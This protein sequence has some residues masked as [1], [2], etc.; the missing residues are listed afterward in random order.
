MPKHPGHLN[1]GCCNIFVF[2]GQSPG[3]Q[4][5]DHGPTPPKGGTYYHWW[6]NLKPNNYYTLGEESSC[7]LIRQRLI[8]VLAVP[9]GRKEVIITIRGTNEPSRQFAFNCP[10]LFALRR[11]V[12]A[13]TKWK[14]LCSKYSCKL[15]KQL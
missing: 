10:I 1:D 11:Q 13:S 9:P 12:I 8:R 2:R 3:S 4:S 5:H 7:L 6:R 14:V 15:I